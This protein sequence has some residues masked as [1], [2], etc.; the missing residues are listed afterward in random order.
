MNYEAMLD[1]LRHWDSCFG[2]GIP[3]KKDIESAM[4]GDVDEDT[5]RIM[6]GYSSRLTRQTITDTARCIDTGEWPLAE[7]EKMIAELIASVPAEHRATAKV[8]LK[9]GCEEVTELVIKYERPETDEE[10]GCNV[11]HALMHARK[12]QADERAQF[13]RLSRKFASG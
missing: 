3:S 1:D 2:G 8:E 9:G 12:Q 7:F 5:R 10:W 4:R 6:R 13:E 11:A